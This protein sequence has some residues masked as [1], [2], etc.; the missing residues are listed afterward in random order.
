MRP[1]ILIGAALMLMAAGN[2]PGTGLGC[3]VRSNIEVM[4]I[5]MDPQYAGTLI[6]G[7][8]GRRSAE[9]VRR[10]MTDK[11]KQPIRASGSTQIGGGGKD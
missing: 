6:E 4:T 11:V 1:V 10:Y 7:G 8:E 5:D 2:A 9:A 3:S